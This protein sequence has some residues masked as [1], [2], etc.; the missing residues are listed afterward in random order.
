MYYPKTTTTLSLYNK[1]KSNHTYQLT[2]HTEHFTD[3][4]SVVKALVTPES[5]GRWLVGLSGQQCFE[6]YEKA[7]ARWY[8]CC[9]DLLERTVRWVFIPKSA[10]GFPAPAYY[11]IWPNGHQVGGL[12]PRGWVETVQ[13]SCDQVSPAVLMPR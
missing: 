12:C 3:I 2:Q 8:V 6:V 10:H 4:G 5:W 1:K 9:E 7:H 11:H 13:V